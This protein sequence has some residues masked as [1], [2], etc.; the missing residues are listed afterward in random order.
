MK[1]PLLWLR[2]LTFTLWTHQL[3][4]VFIFSQ[5]FHVKVDLL[6]H[7]LPESDGFIS[8]EVTHKKSKKCKYQTGLV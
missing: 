7:E 5:I 8:L 4:L 2:C 6:L 3:S 1:F